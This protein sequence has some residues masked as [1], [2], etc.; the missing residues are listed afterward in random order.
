MIGYYHSSRGWQ[1]WRES[2][3]SNI[4]FRFSTYKYSLAKRRRNMTLVNQDCTINK[5]NMSNKFQMN[6]CRWMIT[7]TRDALIIQEFV[8]PQ[9]VNGWLKWYLGVSQVDVMRKLIIQL[10]N[11][12]MMKSQPAVKILLKWKRFVQYP[13][14]QKYWMY[15]HF[16]FFFWLACL[17]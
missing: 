8:L 11:N 5:P 16:F 3:T 9:Y 17:L 7:A 12:A 10:R 2:P 15:D 14:F 4:W 1:L 13:L 6:N